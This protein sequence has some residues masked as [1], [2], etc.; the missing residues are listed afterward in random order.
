[1][2]FYEKF[3]LDGAL[4]VLIIVLVWMGV[5]RNDLNTLREGCRPSRRTQRPMSPI[6]RGGGKRRVVGMPYNVP[7]MIAGEPKSSD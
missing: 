5:R 4:V 3:L 7:E 2:N 6:D 1:V